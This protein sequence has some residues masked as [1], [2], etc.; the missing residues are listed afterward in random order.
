MKKFKVSGKFE[1][2]KELGVTFED[3]ENALQSERI[4]ESLKWR[5]L[6]GQINPYFERK[7]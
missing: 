4:K 3:F 6:Y 7:I 2:E 1:I 5:Y